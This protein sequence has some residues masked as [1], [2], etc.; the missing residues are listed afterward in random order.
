MKI[1]VAS[2]N[3][4]QITAHTGH[5]RRFWVYECENGEIRDQQFLELSP[6]QSFHETSPQANHPLDGIQALL[7]RN[8]GWGLQ[9]HLQSRGIQPIATAKTDPEAAVRDYLDNSQP[10]HVPN[11]QLFGRNG[12]RR[13]DRGRRMRRGKRGHPA[14]GFLNR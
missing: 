13:S 12:G 8:F 14:G 3:Q 2:Q 7:A 11:R 6:Q 1:A 4:H 9:R 5:C 10:E